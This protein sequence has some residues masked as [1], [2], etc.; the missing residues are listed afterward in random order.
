MEDKVHIEKIAYLERMA[1]YYQK[2]NKEL[3][4]A[5]LRAIRWILVELIIIIVLVVHIVA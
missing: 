2:Q 4:R 1:A 5:L 3:N